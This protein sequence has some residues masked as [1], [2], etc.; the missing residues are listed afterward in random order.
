M[1][2]GYHSVESYGA[3]PYFVKRPNGNLMIDSPRYNARLASAIEKEGGI[4][5][6]ILTHKDDVADHEK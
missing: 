4:Q 1:H 6:I 5:Y 3:T 2:L